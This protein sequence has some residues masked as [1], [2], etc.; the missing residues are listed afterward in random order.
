MTA[1][2]EAAQPRPTRPAFRSRRSALHGRGTGR[3]LGGRAAP[4]RERRGSG[5]EEDVPAWRCLEVL[6]A[7]QRRYCRRHCARKRLRG[8]RHQRVRSHSAAA[9]EPSQGA[10][11]TPARCC[12]TG[13][14]PLHWWSGEGQVLT[15]ADGLR[16]T[17][18]LGEYS[19]ISSAIRMNGSTAPW[20]DVAHTESTLG[21]CIISTRSPSP[22]AVCRR[23]DL[24][25]VRFTN[26]GTEANLMA[27]GAAQPIQR[28]ARSWLSTAPIT[29]AILP[30]ATAA[31]R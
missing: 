14:F 2:R 10:G 6:N 25:L 31:R 5:A 23:F 8:L 26:S 16:Y 7:W 22:K 27:L 24:D 20:P 29:A 1:D 4:A 19:A 21:A 18:F 17:D 3:L 11:G 28:A 15:D 9:A 30:A 12:S 13:L